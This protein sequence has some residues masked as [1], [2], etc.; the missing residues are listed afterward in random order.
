[1]TDEMTKETAMLFGSAPI[2]AHHLL[3]LLATEVQPE[4]ARRMGLSPHEIPRT[5]RQRDLCTE[6]TAAVKH[7]LSMCGKRSGYHIHCSGKEPSHE[8][9]LDVLWCFGNSARDGI[10]LACESEWNY[11]EEVS[12]DFQKLLVVKAPLKLLIYTGRESMAEPILARVKQ[13]IELYPH[14]VDEEEYIFVG[15]DWG[16]TPEERMTY[17]HRYVVRGNG[18]QPNITLQSIEQANAVAT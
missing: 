11:E 14:H 17:A 1:M 5:Q 13:E 8:L 2:D 18:R 4:A 12:K 16:R 7:V 10:A 9:M 15:L 6:W 3:R